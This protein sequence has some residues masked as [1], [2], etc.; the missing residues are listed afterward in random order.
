[1]RYLNDVKRQR[2]SRSG[3]RAWCI[4]GRS[5]RA[6]LGVI[7]NH[8]TLVLRQFSGLQREVD[9]SLALPHEFFHFIPHFER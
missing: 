2:T 4:E 3:N 1:M 6:V 8:I 7:R 5:S 9:E